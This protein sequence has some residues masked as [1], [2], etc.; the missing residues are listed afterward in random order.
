MSIPRNAGKS[1]AIAGCIAMTMALAG[2]FDDERAAKPAAQA[3]GAD[4]SVAMSD[5]L[6]ESGRQ[7][8]LGNCQPCHG[9]GLA[10]APK[11]GD[12]AAWAP[13]LAQ[14]IDV[15]QRHALEGFKGKAG[16]EMPPKGGHPE[17]SD[18]AVRGA[19]AYMAALGK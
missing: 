2:C 12:K 13:R 4:T 14:G 7:V 17:L 1:L 19:V 10:G 18:D 16:D 5:P 3:A 8:W 9:T 15:L 6:L 11:V